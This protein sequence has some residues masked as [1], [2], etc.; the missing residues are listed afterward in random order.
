MVQ[1][2]IQDVLQSVQQDELLQQQGGSTSEAGDRCPSDSASCW[3]VV[4]VI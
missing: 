2:N 4:Q 3:L 1:R